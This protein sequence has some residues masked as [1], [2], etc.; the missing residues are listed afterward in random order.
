ML[1]G[2]LLKKYLKDF[3]TFFK[4]KPVL[5]AAEGLLAEGLPAE[6]PRVEGPPAEVPP[7]EG[8]PSNEMFQKK[9]CA[10]CC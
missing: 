3:Q 7:A 5:F 2:L 9:T 8:P 1:K 6:G 4:R 10:I